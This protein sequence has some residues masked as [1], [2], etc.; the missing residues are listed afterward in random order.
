MKLLL[1]IA[2]AAGLVWFLVR[3]SSKLAED[4]SGGPTETRDQRECPPG[5]ELNADGRCEE[6][7]PSRRGG[8]A[9]EDCISAGTCYPCG[10]TPPPAPIGKSYVCSSGLWKLRT[11]RDE[12]PD[13]WETTLIDMTMLPI[14]MTMALD[15]WS[16]APTDAA[17]SDTPQGDPVLAME[18]E[19]IG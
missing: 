6:R 18:A 10:T 4:E 2:A 8:G 11:N 19:W 9:P 3:R 7:V 5:A 15:T 13:L 1:G 14:E 16:D 17:T 12:S